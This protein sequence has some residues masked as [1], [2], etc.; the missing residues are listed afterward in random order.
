ML[1]R[2]Y[3]PISRKLSSSLSSAVE[4]RRRSSSYLSIKRVRS[5][6]C[7]RARVSITTASITSVPGF[8]FRFCSFRGFFDGTGMGGGDVA[9]RALA[10]RFLCWTVAGFGIIS[11]DG[12]FAGVILSIDIRVPSRKPR[13]SANSLHGL[14]AFSNA[15]NDFC[16]TAFS[17]R[18]TSDFKYL[19]SSAPC[20]PQ[21]QRSGA[22]RGRKLDRQLYGRCLWH[23]R[24]MI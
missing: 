4:Y 24:P 20:L 14:I 16:F 9:S 19:P 18:I 13:A 21:S 11:S 23:Y 6:L 2:F 3:K 8:L 7:F 10:F 1:L 12:W 17:S 15:V 22:G 5:R